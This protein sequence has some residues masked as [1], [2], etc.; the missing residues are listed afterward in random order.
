MK[1][2]PLEIYQNILSYKSPTIKFNIYKDNKLI[3]SLS[4]SWHNT[5]KLILDKKKYT[6][7][8]DSNYIKLCNEIILI[9]IS[10]KKILSQLYHKLIIDNY[11]LYFKINNIEI[12]YKILNILFWNSFDVK[13]DIDIDLY[14]VYK[15]IYNNYKDII[16]EEKYENNILHLYKDNINTNI[17][18]LIINHSKIFSRF[19]VL[20][21]NT[22]T[23]IPDNVIIY[24]RHLPIYYESRNIKYYLYYDNYKIHI[25]TITDELYN[26]ITF[27]KNIT[28]D[29][30]Y[31]N[32]KNKKG[33]NLIKIIN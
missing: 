10:K 27:Y 17:L 30:F 26:S 23:I 16:I 32:V 7:L 22:W 4:H 3:K 29:I 9:K 12:P 5:L 1:N 25:F 2:L 20:Y 8:K 33:F 15:K 21:N 6:N 11:D 19:Y 18:E 28:C 24:Y 13:Q 14:I 31:N